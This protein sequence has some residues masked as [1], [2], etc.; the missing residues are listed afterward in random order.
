MKTIFK[1]IL[2]FAL[3]ALAVAAFVFSPAPTPN[4]STAGYILGYYLGYYFLQ[5]TLMIAGL[6]LLYKS[7]K[8][9]S[10]IN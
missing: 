1:T 3:I 8:T 6:V 9:S 7:R 10:Q 4:K 5:L 2:A